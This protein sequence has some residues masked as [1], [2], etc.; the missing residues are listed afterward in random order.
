M[1]LELERK[2]DISIVYWLR[3]VFDDVTNIDILDEYSVKEL[4][5][6]SLALQTGLITGEDF[7]LGD[8]TQKLIRLWHIDIYAK[9]TEQR[10][11]IAYRLLREVDDGI[12]VYDY[13]EGFPPDYDPTQ[14]GTIGVFNKGYTPIAVV[15]ELLEK[16][17]WRGSVTIFT[18]YSEV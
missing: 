12:P 11:D 3:D 2:K 8:R 7:Q 4:Q 10:N 13:D 1:E 5:V 16:M 9:S 14:I 18:E 15:P 6:P 17:Y